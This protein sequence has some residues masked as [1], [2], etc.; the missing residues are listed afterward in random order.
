[1]VIAGICTELPLPW[2]VVECNIEVVSVD[3]SVLPCAAVAMAVVATL[4]LVERQIG[5]TSW[6]HCVHTVTN[7]SSVRTRVCRP[8]GAL[9]V[10]AHARASVCVHAVVGVCL[11]GT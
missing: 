9:C 7:R 3:A 11:G 4:P 6:K 2:P 5:R 1:M 8:L 10:R